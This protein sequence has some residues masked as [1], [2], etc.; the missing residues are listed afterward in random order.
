MIPL[1]YFS[2]Q[3]NNLDKRA[4]FSSVISTTKIVPLYREDQRRQDEK[5][6]APIR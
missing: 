1:G 2:N 3:D 4:R 6:G 5:E